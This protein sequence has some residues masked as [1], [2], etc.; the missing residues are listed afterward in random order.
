[1][2]LLGLALREGERGT[3]VSEGWTGGDEKELGAAAVVIVVV[4]PIVLA[5]ILPH[6]SL[7]RG[8]KQDRLSVLVEIL[9]GLVLIG[10]G[11][12]G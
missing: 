11:G 3:R 1:M 2:I 7:V 8:R 6:H 5:L 12:G 10:T 9:L 4:V